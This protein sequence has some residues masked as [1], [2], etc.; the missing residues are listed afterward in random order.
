MNEI[1]FNSGYYHCRRLIDIALKIY[2]RT[3]L[4]HFYILCKLTR[5]INSI[6]YSFLPGSGWLSNYTE[7]QER[8]STLSS[9]ISSTSKKGLRQNPKYTSLVRR[10]N[11]N[12]ICTEAPL[13]R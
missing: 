8:R 7:Y 4:P 10:K 9:T 5:I 11:D 6:W 1:L 12:P 13:F 3:C 2:Q